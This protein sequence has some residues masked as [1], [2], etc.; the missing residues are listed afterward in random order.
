[1]NIAY[2]GAYLEWRKQCD[3]FFQ[4]Q[5]R[6]D[7]PELKQLSDGFSV[8]SQPYSGMKDGYPAKMSENF[9]LDEQ[10]E[11]VYTWRNLDRING[12]IALFQHSNSRHYL[13]FTT[14]LYGYSVLE[15]ESGRD[16]HYIPSKAHPSGEEE[17]DETFIWCDA[18]YDRRSDLLAV[19]GCFWADSYSVLILDFSDPFREQPADSWIDLHDRVDPKYRYTDFEKYNWDEDGDLHIQERNWVENTGWVYDEILCLPGDELRSLLRDNS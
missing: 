13:L 19:C 17:F 18:T 14:E 3:H 8:R 2:T 15:I 12:T 6:T 9:L 1:M 16:F 10:G 5:Y 11:T 4:P 7:S